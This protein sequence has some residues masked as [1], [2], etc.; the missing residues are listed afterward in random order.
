MYCYL[1]GRKKIVKKKKKKRGF[2]CANIYPYQLSRKMNR[3]NVIWLRTDKMRFYM[4]RPTLLS[5]HTLF[6]HFTWIHQHRAHERVVFNFK[7]WLISW[8]FKYFK[9][10]PTISL[11]FACMKEQLQLIIHLSRMTLE[12]KREKSGE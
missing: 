5:L 2:D 1:K 8:H 10:G 9:W 12:M 3:V 7:I 6:A 4:R 11:S